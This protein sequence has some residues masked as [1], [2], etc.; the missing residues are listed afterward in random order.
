MPPSSVITPNPEPLVVRR[1]WGQ[2]SLIISLVTSGIIRFLLL[3]VASPLIALASAAPVPGENL[4]AERPFALLERMAQALETTDFEGTF[5]YQYGN[6]LSAMRVVHRLRNGDSQESLLT[7]NG[8]IRTIGRNGQSVSCL[9]SGGQSVLLRREHPSGVLA[10]DNPTP[11]PDWQALSKHYRF[12]LLEATRVAGRAADVVAIAP[13][14][15]LR[16]GYRFSIDRASGL[17]LRTALLDAGGLPIQQLMFTE[18]Q[19]GAEPSTEAAAAAQ[20]AVS[21]AR[22]PTARSLGEPVA[23]PVAD[24]VAEPGGLPALETNV[25]IAGESSGVA[26]DPIPLTPAKT[27][28]K[29]WEFKELPDGFNVISHEWIDSDEGAQQEYFLLGDG[30]ASVS[31]YVEQSEQ[32]GLAGQTQMAA[33]HAAGKWLDGYQI[34]AVGEVPAETVTALVDAISKKPGG[35]EGA[36]WS[37]APG[38]SQQE[39]SP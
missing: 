3:C 11:A 12:G 1:G 15:N 7:L 14:D 18:V 39:Q 9:L 13:R 25:E 36:A 6:S 22:Q 35:E 10:R 38:A 5:V 24:P 26:P 8:P 20:S 28:D 29:N 30:L 16:Y 32:P 37:A 21:S 33:I 23:D 17:P 27:L 34:T 31:V 2:V 19:F 4:A